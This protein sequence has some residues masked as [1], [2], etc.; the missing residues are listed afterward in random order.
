MQNIPVYLKKIR[1][2]LVL[3]LAAGLLLSSCGQKEAKSDTTAAEEG[4]ASAELNPE[5]MFHIL[6]FSESDPEDPSLKE[7]LQILEARIAA[8]SGGKYLFRETELKDE[9]AVYPAAEAW[10]PPECF[11]NLDPGDEAKTCLNRPVRL[12]LA[13]RKDGPLTADSEVVEVGRSDLAAAE[14]KTGCPEGIRPLD[15]GLETEEF[16]YVEF[17]FTEEFMEKNPQIFEWEAPVFAHDIE[18]YSSYYYLSLIPDPKS[19]KFYLTDEDPLRTGES[20]ALP[21]IVYDYTHPALNDGFYYLFC[22]PV[23]WEQGDE[24]TGQYQTVPADLT[25]ETTVYIYSMTGSFCSDEDWQQAET[26]VKERMDTLE[27]PYSYGQRIGNDRTIAIRCGQVPGIDD[28][29]DMAVTNPA[30]TLNTASSTLDVYPSEVQCSYTAE[31]GS[32][33]FSI[34]MSEENKDVLSRLSWPFKDS[35]EG[36]IWLSLSAIP[37]LWTD[38]DSVIS[39]GKITFTGNALTGDG[40]FSEDDLRLVR[41]VRAM[42]DGESFITEELYPVPNFFLSRTELASFDENGS[43]NNRGWLTLDSAAA[44]RNMRPEED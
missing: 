39:D 22:S 36:R 33:S 4:T 38:I 18:E 10:F 24:I 25:G 16:P 44:V 12:Y 17:R 41:L 29:V 2:G 23:E 14:M 13:N 42:L 1:T 11:G 5:E 20:G 32:C 28:L 43:L 30:V 34:D 27:I 37:L 26:A 40:R 9:D 21:A 7:D 3:L 19:R 15:Y 6:L 8:Y 35:G 31:N